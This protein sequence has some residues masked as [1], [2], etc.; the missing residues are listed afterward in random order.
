RR[1]DVRAADRHHRRAGG[2]RADHAGSPG[3][4]DR[5]CRDRPRPER[6]RLHRP[7]PWRRRRPPLRDEV[8]RI[9]S[10]LK[11]RRL[12]RRWQ[13]WSAVDPLDDY[14]RRARFG[15]ALAVAFFLLLVI[16]VV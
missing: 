16:L 8:T 6:A 9:L 14:A 13:N 7:R 10:E 11:Q 2:N 12:A 5:R 1:R 3:G 15:A 4:P